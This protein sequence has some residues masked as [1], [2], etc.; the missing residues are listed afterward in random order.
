MSEG[1]AVPDGLHYTKDHE[2]ARVE[3]D[4]VVV[5]I[6]DHA[7]HALGDITYAELPETGAEAVRGEELVA[8]ES[9][10]AAV[11]VYAPVSGTVVE[12]NASLADA[13]EKTNADPYGEGWLCK[14]GDY[15]KEDLDKL[16]DAAG[17]R[18]F[19]AQEEA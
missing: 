4:A 14:I 15:R 12:V 19:L 17:Y 11:D 16:L 3:G 6:T 1:T 8:V 13:P 10:K 9:A 18:D 2:W 5:G 7:Q